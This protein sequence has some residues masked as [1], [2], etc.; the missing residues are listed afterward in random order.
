VIKAIILPVLRLV[1]VI[2]FLVSFPLLAGQQW[3]LE[4]LDTGLPQ[5]FQSGDT[6]FVEVELRNQGSEA[7]DPDTGFALAAHWFLPGNRRLQ[8]EGPR[9][10]FPEVVHSGDT[11][12]IKAELAVPRVFGPALVQWDVIQDSVFWI[13]ERSGRLPRPV[14]VEI[15]K[16]RAFDLLEVDN[17]SW[18]VAGR[19]LTA[20][21]LIRNTGALTWDA[22]ER[23]GVAAHWRRADGEEIIW[24]GPR[25]RFQRPVKSGETVAIEVVAAVPAHEGRWL[26]EWDVVQEGVGWFSEESWNLG[27]PSIVVVLP[28]WSDAWPALM[29]TLVLALFVVGVGRRLWPGRAAAPWA[30]L[31]WF[32]GV[33]LLV[34]QN[35]V[36]TGSRGILLGLI[37]MTAM[38][39]I[40]ALSPGKL[41]PWAAWFLGA[42]WVVFLI[43]DRIFLRAFGDLPSLAS[44]NV[45][46]ESGHFGESLAGLLTPGDL[47]LLVAAGSGFFVALPVA[48]IRRPSRRPKRMAGAVIALVLM[49]VA[50]LGRQDR[51]IGVQQAVRRVQVAEEIGV[52]AFHYLD[53]SSWF[54]ESILTAPVRIGRTLEAE[55]WFRDT[56][57]SRSRGGPHFG[58]AGGCNLVMVQADKLQAFVVG[59]EIDGE[60]VTPTLNRWVREG[61]LLEHVTDQTRHDRSSDTE[62]LTQLSLLPPVERSAVIESAGNRFTSLAG[63]F[64]EH[65]YYT[66]SAVAFGQ[67][68]WNKRH[69]H[70]TYGFRHR[71][72]LEDF[73]YDE[74]AGRNSNDRSFLKQMGDRLSTLPVPFC[75]WM[76]TS[77]VHHPDEGF[78][79]H[80]EVFSFGKWEGGPV[81]EYLRTMRLIDAELGDLE[82]SIQ[83]AGLND[84][85]VIL[86]W[87]SRASG[88]EWTPEVAALMGVGFNSAGWYSSQKIPVV[89]RTP[90]GLGL[91]GVV[92]WPAGHIDVAPT[93]AALMGI[94]PANQA[95]MGRNLL[96]SPGN[97][98]VVGKYGCWTDPVHVFLQGDDGAL[99]SGQCLERATLEVETPEACDN[100]FEEA[101]LRQ[102]ISEAVLRY[103]LQE[104]LSE[105]LA[106]MS[107]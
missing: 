72:F 69:L 30:D 78:P 52:V 64:S 49:A 8:W 88:L 101:A 82:R 89:F 98:P 43:G 11:V 76:V 5:V 71:L 32:V 14:V 21:L 35:L 1:F 3:D 29:L 81:G 75:S 79:A 65:G 56:A 34:A 7:W 55:K 67:S 26:V 59:L 90:Q 23:F 9:T 80:T 13:S 91:S 86:V 33:P 10:V 45:L 4:V 40:L 97:H 24:E 12:R 53:F 85:T 41:R 95:W 20:T 27:R 74:F 68:F 36:P 47:A 50:A 57:P 42:A 58:I 93:I 104:D 31:L 6:V 2:Q 105:A 84:T 103:D 37:L 19:Q 51:A 22:G 70:R 44:T 94:D 38:A 28:A 102:S 62:L 16:S 106:E 39:G 99:R 15:V 107:D 96:G 87:G 77:V 60:E 92:E 46:A 61:L 83:S 25:T 73:D 63:V 17:A 66:V 48:Q 54:R 100:A 18:P